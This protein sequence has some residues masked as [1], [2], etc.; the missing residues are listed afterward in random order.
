MS[1]VVKKNSRRT[2][3]N[4]RR[5]QFLKAISNYHKTKL[6]CSY[7]I[8]LNQ[9]EIKF[10]G[11]GNNNIVTVTDLLSSCADWNTYKT[12]FL[13]Y[14]L[15]GVRVTCSPTPTIQKIEAVQTDTGYFP[16]AA[17]ACPATPALALLAVDD[18]VDYSS[19]I[20]S[21]KH[22]LLSYQNKTSSYFSLTGGSVGWFETRNTTVQPG[23][24][25]VNIQQVA[26][27]G[28]CHWQVV[29]DFYIMFKVTV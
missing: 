8:E 22:Q 23:R 3:R 17:F 14:K 21:N 1:K 13:S 25:A 2:N 19:I 16:V 5:A 24:F 12:L 28:S 11:I 7:R 10:L 26:T 27:A 4:N 9:V 20:E 15:T 6:S 29:F 18:A